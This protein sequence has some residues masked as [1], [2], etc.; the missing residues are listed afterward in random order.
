MRHRERYGARPLLLSL[1]NETLKE[2][3]W[4]RSF[5][6]DGGALDHPQRA[7]A[8]LCLPPRALSVAPKM[9]VDDRLADADFPQ[10][11]VGY[12]VGDR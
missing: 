12:P 9:E 7:A 5:R 4:P 8:H 6:A 3:R 2:S 10:G 11:Q 1:R